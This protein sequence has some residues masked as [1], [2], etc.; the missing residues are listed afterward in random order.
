[1][2]VIAMSVPTTPW[3]RDRRDSMARVRSILGQWDGPYLELTDR[4]LNRVWAA[5]LWA[6]GLEC[7]ADVLCSIQDDTE[8]S[9]QFQ[10]ILRACLANVPKGNVL[11]LSSVHPMQGE[12]ARQG[13]RFYRTQSWLCGW[14]W[15]MWR[16]DLVD[17]LAWQES[18]A[19]DR[20]FAAMSEDSLLNAFVSATGRST[21][22]PVPAFLDHDVTIASTYDNDAHVHRRPLVTWRAY[23]VNEMVHP[24]FWRTG[25]PRLLSVPRPNVCWFCETNA[26]FVSAFKTGASACRKCISG[27]AAEAIMRPVVGG[28]EEHNYAAL[29]TRPRRDP[30][31]ET[32]VADGVDAGGQPARENEPRG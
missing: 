31:E 32:P 8:P 22:H 16:D 15:C 29:A 11:G 30:R 5:K 12:I 23:D 21:Y 3:I 20:A 4:A 9:P 10:R 17:F 1:M 24:E 28:L 6:W 25:T 26:A 13:E 18:V 14:G 2:T 27:M 19:R 7:G